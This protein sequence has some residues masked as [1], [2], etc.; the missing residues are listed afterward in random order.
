MMLIEINYEKREERE[1]LDWTYRD[2]DKGKLTESYL[3][4][5]EPFRYECSDRRECASYYLHPENCKCVRD[6]FDQGSTQKHKYLEAI[7]TKLWT[8]IMEKDIGE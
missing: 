1:T 3:L 8:G 6:Y 2:P 5:R 7:K 4:G